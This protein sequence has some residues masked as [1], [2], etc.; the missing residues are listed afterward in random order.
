MKQENTKAI[1][2]APQTKIIAA[3]VFYPRNQDNPKSKLHKWKWNKR[4]KL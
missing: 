3:S 4:P 2:C 1:H